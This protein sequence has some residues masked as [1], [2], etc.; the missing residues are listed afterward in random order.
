MGTVIGK[1]TPTTVVLKTTVV[2][3]ELWIIITYLKYIPGK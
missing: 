3:V 2:G 1:A